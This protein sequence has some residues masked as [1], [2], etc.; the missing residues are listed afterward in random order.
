MFGKI[1]AMFGK[2]TAM[3]ALPRKRQERCAAIGYKG[4]P[5]RYGRK[6]EEA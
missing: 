1:T 5:S 4:E 3:F 6:F 2:I